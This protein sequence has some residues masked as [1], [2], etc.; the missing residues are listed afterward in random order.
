MTDIAGKLAE[1]LS[2]AF[3]THERLVFE[4]SI[5]LNNRKGLTYQEAKRAKENIT[6]SREELIRIVL[7]AHKKE[8]T[9]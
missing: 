7:D 2:D 3:T 4:V 5:S 1:K 9:S 8:L 6:A